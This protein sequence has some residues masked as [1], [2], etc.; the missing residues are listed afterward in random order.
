MTY[1]HWMEARE[2]AE[3]HQAQR[4]IDRMCNE[5]FDHVRYA[6]KEAGACTID[7]DHFM[8]RLNEYRRA[9][10]KRANMLYE[11]ISEGGQEE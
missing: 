11:R 6:L 8:K 9:I 7:L 10:E 3:A 4:T 5:F 2:Y 1:S